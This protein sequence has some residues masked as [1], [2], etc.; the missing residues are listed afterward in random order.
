MACLSPRV[1]AATVVG[2]HILRSWVS[3][4][5]DLEQ[6]DSDLKAFRHELARGQRL[7]G[8]SNSALEA[9]YRESEIQRFL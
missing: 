7:L 4:G 5:P 3:T 9:C 2:S 8:A 1:V 6:L